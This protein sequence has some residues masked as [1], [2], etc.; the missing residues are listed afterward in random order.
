MAGVYIETT[1]PSYYFETRSAPQVIAWR[2]VTRQWWDAYRHDYQ[3]FTSR[4]VL[5]ELARA[6]KG[7]ARRAIGLLKGVELLDEPAGLR[8]VVE[9]YIEHRLMPVDAGG[10]AVHLAL[11]SLHSVDFL[12]TWNC[13]HLANANKVQH[14]AVLNGRLRV[15]VPVI[16]TPLTLMPEEE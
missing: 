12:L 15:H 16:T 9:Y 6:P 7:K 11:A 8:D 3:L 1:I 4:L 14:L 10:D 2:E 5:A 13:Q